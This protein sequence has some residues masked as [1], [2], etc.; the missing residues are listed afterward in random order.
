ML[1]PKSSTALE[2]TWEKLHEN[3]TNGNI[4]G[5]R[6][7]YATQLLSRNSCPK[8]KDVLGVQIT[9]FNLTGL[10]EATSYFVAVQAGTRA[11][12]GSN[13]NILTNTTL[14]DS[15]YCQWI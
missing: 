1:M 2:V 6:V 8:F 14:E 12:F 4:T 15:K 3:D 13:G 7:C 9:T 5:Y 10:N 11:G